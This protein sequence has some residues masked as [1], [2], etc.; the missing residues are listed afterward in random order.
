MRIRLWEDRL[1]GGRAKFRALSRGARIRRGTLPAGLLVVFV[2]ALMTVGCGGSS[3]TPASTTPGTGA[4]FTFIGD[5]P[6]CD[7]LS[8]SVFPSELDLH[9]QGRPFVATYDKTVW[10]TNI[11]PTSPVVEMTSLRDTST[12][13]NL[14][15]IPAGTYDQA[16]LTIV[17]NNA[18]T[19][20]SGQT[21][22]FSN[23]TTNVFTSKV[24]IPIQ[25]PLVVTGGKVSALELDLNLPQSLVED[26]QGQMT[27]AVNWAFTARPVTA[28]GANGFGEF[29]NLYGFVRTVNP[30]A[31]AG[32]IFTGSFLLQTL[33]QTLS[34]AGPALNVELTDNTN[35]CFENNCQQAV[36]DLSQLPTGN[37]VGV[38]AYI[39][40]NG[41]V[42]AKT[43][44]VG[45]RESLSQQ[46]LAYMGPVLNVTKD[47]NGN[48]TQFTMLVRQTQPNDATDIPV[49]TAVT[50][51]LPTTT[52]YTPYLVSTDLA[53]LANSGNLV[54]G[55]NTIVP[56]QEVV[57]SGVFSKPASGP[58]TVTADS[59]TQQLQ[60]VQGAFSGLVGSPGSDDKTG[61]FQLVPCNG[62]LTAYPLMVVTDARTAFLN[63][64]G[65]ST[66]SPTSPVMARG[67][68]FFA[69]NGTTINGVN[70]PANTMVLLAS[71]VRQF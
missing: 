64:S 7:L 10:P 69:L 40:D 47:P 53:N 19:Y 28:S 32:T 39:D 16:I 24:T 35:L 31:T 44:Q 54:L 57:V 42:I 11:S 38:D 23:F 22:P 58:V 33:S 56:G 17:V 5:T 66:L 46:L 34:G 59:V 60:S 68:V 27:G 70:I 8:F 37:Y 4:L 18:V 51:S 67:L 36:T 6:E 55:S 9:R 52:T 49:D 20:D 21:P 14:T 45:T 41:N 50:V 43:I 25:P 62:L 29:D 2:A 61:A 48:V 13:T 12:I 63:T 30:S 15:S 3:S 1:V 71:S 26:S 65:L